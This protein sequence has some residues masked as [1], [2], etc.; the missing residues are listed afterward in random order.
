M[1]KKKSITKTAVKETPKTNLTPEI[2]EAIARA[3][4][5][6]ERFSQMAHGINTFCFNV[7]EGREDVYEFSCAISR[8]AIMLQ[9]DAELT[10]ENL[11]KI[12]E[13]G[14]Q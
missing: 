7:D 12:L 11:G 10:A 14:A 6:V 5:R 1:A 9:E 2:A 8:I 4:K 13:G 3:K